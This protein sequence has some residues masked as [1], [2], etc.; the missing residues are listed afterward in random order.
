M[1]GVT[2]TVQVR[3]PKCAALSVS[4]YETAPVD[5][6]EWIGTLEATASYCNAKNPRVVHESCRVV[7]AEACVF[8]VTAQ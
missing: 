1:Q 5:C 8:V 7:G 2:V 3:A 6:E 4:G